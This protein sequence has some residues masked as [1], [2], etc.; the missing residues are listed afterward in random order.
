VDAAWAAWIMPTF[1]SIPTTRPP[2]PTRSAAR[3]ATKPVPQA[4]N[5]TPNPR[6]HHQPHVPFVELRRLPTELPTLLRAHDSFSSLVCLTLTV[7]G[8]RRASAPAWSE[9]CCSTDRTVHMVTESLCWPGSGPQEV[10]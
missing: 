8:A 10:S 3:R 6:L 2:V 5:Q 7:S 1:R 4:I 9:A